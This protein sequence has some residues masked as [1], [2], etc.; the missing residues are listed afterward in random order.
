MIIVINNKEP[1]IPAG[2][3]YII[4]YEDSLEIYGKGNKRVG[5]DRRTDRIIFE[6]DIRNS[7]QTK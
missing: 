6:Y 2:Y 1:K 5:V 3:E 7:P 4:S